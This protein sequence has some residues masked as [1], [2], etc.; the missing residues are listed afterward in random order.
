MVDDSANVTD[1]Y[2][3]TKEGAIY[4]HTGTSTQPYTFLGEFGVM[5]VNDSTA[6]VRAR[7]L[8]LSNGSNT[9]FFN[10]DPYNYDLTNPQTINRYV[11]ALNNA[12]NMCDYSGLSCEKS[13]EGVYDD[14]LTFSEAKEHYQNGNGTPVYVDLNK[15]NLN[16][17]S[18]SDFK[19][20]AI[21]Y[22][23]LDGKDFRNVN[24]AVVHGTI[25]L[26]LIPNT[27]TVQVAMNN[28]LEIKGRGG[29][30]DFNVQHLRDASGISGKLKVAARNTANAIGVVVNGTK[31]YDIPFFDLSIPYYSGGTPFPIYY[32]GTSTIKQ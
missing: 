9:R 13:T 27:N 1:R 3:Y 31:F 8:D 26:E 30:F 10:R 16:G 29:M 19:N 7:Y 20:N 25:G 18:V 6:F 11:Y 12:V 4:S 32:L 21:V 22:A 24:D 23:E 15:I 28:H 5:R 17:I 2:I 14:Y